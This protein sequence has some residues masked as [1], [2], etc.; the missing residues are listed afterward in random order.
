MF[1]G[2]GEF[3][4]Q[5]TTPKMYTDKLKL[6]LIAKLHLNFFTKKTGKDDIF[7]PFLLIMGFECQLLMLRLAQ[8]KLYYLEEV[9]RS[10]FPVSKKKID[11]GVIEEMVN[12]LTFTRVNITL[13]TQKEH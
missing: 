8:P 3:A 7:V 9:G 11:E 2:L 5:C 12:L 6:A 13:R 10:S 4:G 1:K